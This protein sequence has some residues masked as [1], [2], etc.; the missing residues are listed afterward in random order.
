MTR[1]TLTFTPRCWRTPSAMGAGRGPSSRERIARSIVG[2]ILECQAELGQFRAFTRLN[3]LIIGGTFVRV[4]MNAFTS[5]G[6]RF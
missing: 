3:A 6:T 1:I 4:Q 2:F 5:G